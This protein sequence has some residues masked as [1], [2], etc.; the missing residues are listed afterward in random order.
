MTLLSDAS[1]TRDLSVSVKGL[2]L[3][4]SGLQKLAAFAALHLMNSS[5][6][7]H[8]QG[9]V[10]VSTQSH[11]RGCREPVPEAKPENS[12]T[13]E[14]LSKSS[15]A[16]SPEVAFVPDFANAKYSLPANATAQRL[17]RAP[18]S[19]LDLELWKG[20]L[21]CLSAKL[22]RAFLSVSWYERR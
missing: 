18:G 17:D 13:N 6:S 20:E 7:R 12:M 19:L 10:S 5:L 15:C 4:T 2:S 22:Q 11:N 21:L 3:T 8:R 9:T 1:V 14:Q 16:D